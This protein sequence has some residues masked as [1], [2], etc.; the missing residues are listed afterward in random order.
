MRLPMKRETVS[1]VPPGDAC[2]I[3]FSSRDGN[4]PSSWVQPA[5]VRAKPTRTVSRLPDSFRDILVSILVPPGMLKLR[6]RNGGLRK[7]PLDRGETRMRSDGV[8]VGRVTWG[9]ATELLPTSGL[10]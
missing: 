10:Q 1:D 4:G 8:L 7:G 9:L 2:T 3:S 5:K 6:G